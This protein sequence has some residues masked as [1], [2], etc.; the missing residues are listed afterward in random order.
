MSQSTDILHVIG[1]G[2]YVNRSNILDWMT[3]E[4]SVD[5]HPIASFKRPA[6]IQLAT[7]LHADRQKFQGGDDDD[8]GEKNSDD[9][10]PSDSESDAL[11]IDMGDSDRDDM[12]ASFNLKSLKGSLN[13]VE[14]PSKPLRTTR[15]VRAHKPAI[16]SDSDIL[17][18]THSQMRQGRKKK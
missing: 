13:E 1:G 10:E 15:T 3:K 7:R 14:A 8:D 9:G 12:S 11:G 16:S 18:E 17:V 6:L 5:T 4:F 2:K